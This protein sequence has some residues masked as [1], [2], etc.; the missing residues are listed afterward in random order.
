MYLF[1][2]VCFFFISLYFH[3]GNRGVTGERGISG[4]PGDRGNPGKDGEPGSPGQPG[5]LHG[6]LKSIKNVFI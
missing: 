2:N 3:S 6:L 1:F 5:C 4:I